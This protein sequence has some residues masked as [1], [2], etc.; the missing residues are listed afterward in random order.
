MSYK[1]EFQLKLIDR[2]IKTYGWFKIWL[3]LQQEG[4]L[5]L[6]AVLTIDIDYTN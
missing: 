5:K 3:F 1:Y 4:G 6:I 2:N